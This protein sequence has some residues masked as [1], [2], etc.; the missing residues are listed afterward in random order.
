MRCFGGL[1]IIVLVACGPSAPPERRTSVLETGDASLGVVCDTVQRSGT[2]YVLSCDGVVTRA[3]GGVLERIAEGGPQSSPSYV[4][5]ELAVGSDGSVWIAE[6]LDSSIVVH[7][8]MDGAWSEMPLP[9]GAG[10]PASIAARSIDEAYVSVV[11]LPEYVPHLCRWSGSAWSCE[12]T[13]LPWFG[14]QL[15]ATESWLY[16]RY[17][18]GLYRYDTTAAL[19]TAELVFERPLGTAE[20]TVLD[21]ET[22]MV[23]TGHSVELRRGGA[24]VELYSSP[25]PV[26]GSVTA[27]ARAADDIWILDYLDDSECSGWEEGECTDSRRLWKQ[28]VVW[29]WDG[30]SLTEVAYVDYLGAAPELSFPATTDWLVPSGPALALVYAEGWLRAER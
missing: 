30:S 26:G 27:S 20:I 3:A 16:W 19:G 13:G 23:T 21:D 29:H 4:S 10:H 5:I 12:P 18:D 17:E 25:S 8:W 2:V 15:V 9:T 28:Y 14:D 1:V 11:D 24:A 6:S 7:V 22:A